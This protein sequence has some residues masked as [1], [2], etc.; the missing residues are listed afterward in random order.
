MKDKRGR[1]NAYGGGQAI[2]RA[3]NLLF[4]ENIMDGV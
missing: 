4:S 3:P 1:V 2:N